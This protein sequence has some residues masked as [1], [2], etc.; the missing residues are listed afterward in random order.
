M[1]NLHLTRAGGVE[2]GSSELA[3]LPRE[4]HGV[5][6]SDAEPFDA[7]AWPDLGQCR[8]KAAARAI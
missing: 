2:C 4:I 7:A 3:S 6:T 5:S 8:Q 1:V